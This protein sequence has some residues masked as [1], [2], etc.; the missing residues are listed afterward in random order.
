MAMPLPRLSM[1]ASLDYPDSLNA[2]NLLL[3]PPEK[4]GVYYA[5]LFTNRST[6]L[7]SGHFVEYPF[8]LQ[9]LYHQLVTTRL[10]LMTQ[11]LDWAE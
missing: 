1:I 4:S 5:A 6:G 11:W 7:Q 10:R 8:V 3:C 2:S 9:R